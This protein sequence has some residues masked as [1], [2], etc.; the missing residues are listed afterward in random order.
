MRIKDIFRLIGYEMNHE[1]TEWISS[2]I[3]Q[4]IIY[5]MVL[6][7]LAMAGN[8]DNMFCEYIRPAYPDG[9]EFELKGFT[10]KDIHTFE[11]M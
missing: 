1:R 3:I 8:V 6:F 5:S 10:E 7:L 4:F 11:K 9:F 2:V